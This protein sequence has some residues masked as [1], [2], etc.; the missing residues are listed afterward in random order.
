MIIFERHANFKCKFG[1]RHF[2]AEGYHV[3][4]VGLNTA[5]IRKYIREQEREDQIWINLKLKN[6]YTLLRV[7]S[8]Q[9][10]YAIIG[11]PIPRLLGEDYKLKCINST[12]YCLKFSY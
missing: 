4:T 10:S 3:S 12:M 7:V 2:L 5:M 9:F 1:N 8:N 11:L 6:T